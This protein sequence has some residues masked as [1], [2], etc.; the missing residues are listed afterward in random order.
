MDEKDPV[1][2]VKHAPVGKRAAKVRAWNQ[3]CMGQVIAMLTDQERSVRDLSDKIA[4]L[5]DKIENV[6]G[7][8]K[9]LQESLVT[10]QHQ[11]SFKRPLFRV[12]TPAELSVSTM[13]FRQCALL[14]SYVWM[15]T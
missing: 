7:N 3:S 12:R 1:K 15:H 11:S 5:N 10:I 13:K 9:T 14:F 8:L 6:E 2:T 4:A